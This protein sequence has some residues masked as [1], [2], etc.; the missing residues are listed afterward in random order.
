MYRITTFEAHFLAVCII[1]KRTS[2]ML[3]ENC[4]DTYGMM[5]KHHLNLGGT[6]AMLSLAGSS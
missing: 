3:V 4:I 6:V 5:H 2:F 1:S